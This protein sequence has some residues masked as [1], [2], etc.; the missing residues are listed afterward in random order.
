MGPQADQSAGDLGSHTDASLLARAARNRG[1]L[2]AEP[3][4]HACALGRVQGGQHIV[5]CLVRR[6]IR[7]SASWRRHRE[8]VGGASPGDRYH[9]V[10]LGGLEKRE[11]ARGLDGGR[12]RLRIAEYGDELAV[13]LHDR[14]PRPPRGCAQG[15]RVSGGEPEGRAGESGCQRGSGKYG[16]CLLLSTH[17][18][19]LLVSGG[20]LWHLAVMHVAHP[21]R[22][23]ECD[24]VG[25]V[26]A[27]RQAGMAAVV[28]EELFG[29]LCGSRDRAG[30]GW[31]IGS[32][33]AARRSSQA[34]SAAVASVGGR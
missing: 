23:R 11:A 28:E 2:A 33:R 30:A 3:L 22:P 25:V 19:W 16:E 27:G 9:G 14:D 34:R 12:L 5:G 26:R 7:T 31:A 1:Q 4:V 20:G 15:R 6:G 32:M 13:P 17:V 8:H 29:G 18:L 10:V 21:G 24:G